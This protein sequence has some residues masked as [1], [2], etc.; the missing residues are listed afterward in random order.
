MHNLP[1]RRSLAHFFL[2]L[3][4]TLSVAEVRASSVTPHPALPGLPLSEH[5]NVRVNGIAVTT[6]RITINPFSHY[7]DIA[8]EG[9]MAS[10]DFE[11]E[12]VVEVAV[13]REISGAIVRPLSR[14]V[15]LSIADGKASFVVSQPGHF[16]VEFDGKQVLPLLIFANPPERNVP[17]KGDPGVIYY[18][19]G[20]HQAG[21]IRVR[22]GE[23]L[24]LAP[25]AFVRGAIVAEDADDVTIRGRGVLY[26]GDYPRGAF[27]DAKFVMLTRC[28]RARVEG[29]TLLD[30]FGW[31]L[32][33]LACRDVEARNVKVVGWRRNTDGINPVSSNGVRI[34]DNFIMG[35]DDGISIKGNARHSPEVT[36][37][38]IVGNVFWQYFMRSIVVGGEM[39]MIERV[40]GI[41]VRNNDIL[42]SSYNPRHPR[43][44]ALSVWNVD[45]ATITDVVFE[46]IR[47]EN[48]HRLVRIGV[49]VNKHSND[50]KR[51]RIEGI[52][53]RN[54]VAH[55]GPAI[56][57]I[58]G[59]DKEHDVK[60]IRFENIVVGGRRVK[61][62]EDIFVVTNEHVS[63]VV[64]D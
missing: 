32:R 45:S 46:D 35:Q 34:V 12:V 5:Y 62:P 6:H 1:G 36:D 42:H 50:D 10:F 9:A 49:A 27:D 13:N 7:R 25:G 41:R 64:F 54:I 21:Q 63:G 23:T 26:G 11:G 47:V 40:A 24:Y 56:I 14:R 20:D 60:D 48:C 52:V 4:M 18:G 44:A 16:V 58:T 59:F 29:I 17:A 51:G 22:S 8:A 43:D 38:E 33:L 31:N 39:S 2:F 55:N 37:I 3:T 57:E 28:R 61:D 15:P 30:G 19:P 53:F